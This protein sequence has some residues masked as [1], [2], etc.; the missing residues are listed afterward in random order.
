MK[1]FYFPLLVVLLGAPKLLLA[2]DISNNADFELSH[3]SPSKLNKT[4]SSS[5]TFVIDAGHGGRDGGCSSKDVN[6]KNITLSVAKKLQAKIEKEYTQVRVLMTRDKDVFVPLHERADLANKA[7]ADLFL[8]IH[9]N[10]IVG[11]SDVRGTESYIMGLHTAREN[12]AVAKR[13]NASIML[14]ENHQ[15]HYDDFDPNSPEGH[16]LMEMYQNLHLDRSL[17]FADLVESRIR[18]SKTYKSRGVRQAGFVVLRQTAMP[19]VLFESG[20]LTNKKDRNFLNTSKGQEFIAEIL[21]LAFQDY[22]EQHGNRAREESPAVEI[23]AVEEE[24]V[25]PPSKPVKVSEPFVKMDE[26]VAS[27]STKKVQPERVNT[28]PK[29]VLNYMVQLGV[30][31]KK[32][33]TEQGHWQKVPRLIVMNNNGV[34]KYFSE[35]YITEHDA[36]DAKINLRANGFPDAFI[37]AFVNGKKVSLNEAK[38]YVSLAQK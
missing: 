14:E 23:A 12:L 30:F 8:S 33:V 16:I 34:Y 5:L 32:I 27:T 20:Y 31:S 11:R 19:S 9:C 7:H 13:E 1:L 2:Q 3:A 18:D 22:L 29:P 37:V 28:K 6:E 38:K 4:L 36:S 24:E 21:Y 17:A 26:P 15:H 25:L 35:G 10:A